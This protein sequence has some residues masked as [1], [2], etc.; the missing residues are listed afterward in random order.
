M[1]RRVAVLAAVVAAFVVVPLAATAAIYTV[2]GDQ[3]PVSETSALM[4]G[5]LNGEWKTLTSD[6][7]YD[8]AT[9]RVV[10]WGTE[11]FE[12]C[13]DRWRNGCDPSD[14]YGT[15]FFKFTAW[16]KYDTQTGAFLTGA[17]IHP[18]TGATGGFEGARGVIGM[19]DTLNADGS[20]STSYRGV[21]NI[22][23]S[24]VWTKSVSGARDRS[25]ASVSLQPT[26]GS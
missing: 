11:S 14:P 18:V 2:S 10:A 16:Q 26:C 6:F 8:E 3:V 1:R 19:K 23:S 15:M 25:L 24:R 22:P 13:V 12:G 20:V 4:S 7:R 9:G 17:C 5:G 21:L